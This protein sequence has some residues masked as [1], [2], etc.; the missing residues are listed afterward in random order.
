MMPREKVAVVEEF[1]NAVKQAG[2]DR[3]VVAELSLLARTLYDVRPRRRR[4][5]QCG[6]TP[7]C[8]RV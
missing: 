1:L 2:Y 4:K 8:M 5:S 7:C 6:P 3:R